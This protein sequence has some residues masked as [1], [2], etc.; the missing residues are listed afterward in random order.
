MTKPKQFT[1][2]QGNPKYGITNELKQEGMETPPRH[3]A[4]QDMSWYYT[5]KI[6]KQIKG[7]RN[8]TKKKRGSRTR[9]M[10]NK[11]GKN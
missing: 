9:K 11:G 1:R 8:P 6:P 5:D 10:F 7:Q 3:P 4:M 2:A